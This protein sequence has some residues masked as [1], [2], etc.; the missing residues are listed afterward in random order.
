MRNENTDA[1]V[2]LLIAD[3]EM[4][5]KMYLHRFLQD[6]F[7]D[8]CQIF[9]AENGRE[10]L[11]VF[12]EEQ[13]QVAIMDIEMPGMN[14][15][16]AAAEMKRQDPN[17]CI[18]F[19]SAYDEFSYARKAISIHA[20]DYLLKPYQEEELLA[21]VEDALRI[22]RT[23][24]AKD[25]KG[26]S[27]PEI[28]QET[29]EE[30]YEEERSGKYVDMKEVILQ[31]LKKHYRTELSMQDVAQAFHYSEAH[32]CK[33]F[34]QAFQMNFT[35]YLTHFRIEKAKQLLGEN[36][37][38]V[39]EVGEAVGYSDANYF[40]K[41]FRRITGKSPSAYRLCIMYKNS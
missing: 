1:K 15:I 34:K 14:G 22:A 9:Q 11:R 26:M 33:L 40:A 4:I 5:E 20:L 6:H 35:A 12:G 17:C 7:A 31:Y 41:V 2:R 13:I 36:K 10:A 8:Q 19:L 16:E 32:F 38:N 27:G 23:E 39:K 25:D 18:I 29:L 24:G 37:Y 3:D 21:V 30:L 28:P